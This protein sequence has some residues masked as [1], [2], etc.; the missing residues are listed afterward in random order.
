MSTGSALAY[1]LAWLAHAPLIDLDCEDGVLRKTWGYRREERATSP[2]LSALD[3]G[4]TTPLLTGFQKPDL[5]PGHPDFELNQPTPDDMADA[6]LKWAGEWGRDWIVVD[7][8]PRGDGRHQQCT[9]HR[10]RRRHAGS[11]QRRRAS[12]GHNNWSVS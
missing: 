12:T 8:P 7:T 4:R 1:E 6:L 11:A 5:L 2:L 3:K 9:V 10:Q